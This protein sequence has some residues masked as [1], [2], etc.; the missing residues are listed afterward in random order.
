MRFMPWL[1]GMWGRLG[2][3]WRGDWTVRCYEGDTLPT[4]LRPREVTHMIDS[5]ESWSVGFPCPCGCNAVIELLLLSSVRPHWKL[6]VDSLNRPTLHPSVWRAE[7]CKSHFWVRS[8]RVM[9]VK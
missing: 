3:W 7:G 1:A 9:W 5:G 2:A 4:V 6:T 8:G